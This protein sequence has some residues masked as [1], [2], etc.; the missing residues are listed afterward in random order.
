MI[1]WLTTHEIRIIV[2][3][4]LIAG[5]QTIRVLGP[6]RSPLLV[7]KNKATPWAPA[8]ALGPAPATASRPQRTLAL[9]AYHARPACLPPPRGQPSHRT[10]PP[11]QPR[12]RPTDH[13]RQR[14]P[15][16]T[17]PPPPRRWR[18]SA[19]ASSS[20]PAAATAL[21]RVSSGAATTS[22][23]YPSPGSSSTTPWTGAS[24]A[25]SSR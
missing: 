12:P 5:A 6:D 20:A 4:N 8:D 24:A 11:T 21:R 18:S 1:R 2:Q 17:I 19:P 3:I 13:P 9:D 14:A 25:T 15:A 16:R 22:A 23:T 7:V 10:R